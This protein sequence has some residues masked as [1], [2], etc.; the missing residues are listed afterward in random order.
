MGI[1]GLSHITLAVSDLRA[2]LGFYCDVLGARQTATSDKVAYLDLG[3][4]W[5]CLSQGPVTKRQ[6]YTHIA[7][8]CEAQNFET[9]SRHIC[10]HSSLWQRN[11]SEGQSLYF[12]DPDGHKLELHVGDMQSR[13]AHYRGDP[14]LGM[15]VLN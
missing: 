9:L 5:L 12:L 4:L 6:D 15:T 10:D 8:S 7:L 2:S 11:Q 1:T 13:L 3:G 14:N